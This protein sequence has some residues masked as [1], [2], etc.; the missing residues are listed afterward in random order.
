MPRG[1]AVLHVPLRNQHLIRSTLPTSHGFVPR[2]STAP[3]PSPPGKSAFVSMF[4]FTGAADSSPALCIP[5]AL[6]FREQVCGGEARIMAYCCALAKAGAALIAARLGT[7]VLQ[8]EGGECALYNV[9]LPI[10]ATGD[11]VRAYLMDTFQAEFDT[12]VPVVFYGG[13]WWA[14]VSGQV[15]LE[16]SDFEFAAEML[17]EMCTRVGE[18]AC[19]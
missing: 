16:M 17:A 5:A 8:R 9:E 7:R 2:D 19:L 4:E 12:A 10:T 15:Y 11:R 3:P 14:R 18:G 6:R 1:C 13:V